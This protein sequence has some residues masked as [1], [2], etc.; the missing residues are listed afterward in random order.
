M[1]PDQIKEF[2]KSFQELEE[3]LIAYAYQILRER[4]DAKDQV[5]EAF[6][7]MMFQEETIVQP[8]AWLYRTVRNLCVNHLRKNQRKHK[9]EEEKQL[10]FFA[11]KLNDSNDANSPN[12]KVEKSEKINRVVHFISLLPEDARNLLRMKFEGQLNYL[13]ISQKTGLTVENVDAKLQHLLLNLVNDLKAEEII[14]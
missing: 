1:S 14:Q 6:K 12:E 7:K 9:E 4:E 8:K 11:D 5:Q 10:D 13:E 3:P 2:E